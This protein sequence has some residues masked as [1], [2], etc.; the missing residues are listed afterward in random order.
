MNRKKFIETG[1]RLLMLGGLAAASGYLVLN[2]KVT[3]TCS[4]SP[5]C[6][7]CGKVSACINPE[8]KNLREEIES[9]GVIEK[10]FNNDSGL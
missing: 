4:I 6:Q 1:G 5:T 7:N 9:T 2:R 8:V 3:T 10:D